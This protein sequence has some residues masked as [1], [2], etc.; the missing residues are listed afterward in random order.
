MTHKAKDFGLLLT[1]QG[2]TGNLVLFSPRVICQKQGESS[3]I[4]IPVPA[5]LIDKGVVVC[6]VGIIKRSRIATVP[7]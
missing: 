3:W 4:L 2:N 5:Y 6:M 1:D 7:L